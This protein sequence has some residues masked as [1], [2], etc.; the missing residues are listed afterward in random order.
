[1]GWGWGSEGTS[2][3]ERDRVG[4]RRSL[5]PPL[6]PLLP[7]P[8]E[9]RICRGR[10]SRALGNSPRLPP[11][12]LPGG[13]APPRT[14]APSPPPPPSG[15]CYSLRLRSGS[16]SFLRRES[17]GCLLSGCERE[18]VRDHLAR[19]AWTPGAGSEAGGLGSEGAYRRG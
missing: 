9:G 15:S 17:E 18:K 12:P 11:L 5:K 8:K 1:M 7:S 10:V 4:S 3:R 2:D 14:G 13:E 19:W 16:T 6:L